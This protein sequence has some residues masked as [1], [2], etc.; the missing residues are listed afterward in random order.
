VESLS[1][2]IE[3]FLSENLGSSFLDSSGSLD[4]VNLLELPGLRQV[5]PTNI[6]CSFVRD[7]YRA[8]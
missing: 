5:L 2:D 8:V 6:Q 4:T 1:S 3:E 7:T